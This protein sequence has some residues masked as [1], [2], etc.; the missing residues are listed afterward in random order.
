MVN[1]NPL[2]CTCNL[3]WLGSWLRKW[4]RETRKVH[5]LN[6]EALLKSYS[7]V[8]LTKCKI[9]PESINNSQSSDRYESISLIDLY[10]SDLNCKSLY[11]RLIAT[12]WLMAFMLIMNSIFKRD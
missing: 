11:P 4:L 8:K 2:I 9:Y 10:P 5:R 6:Y 12:P 1:D 3:V 7:N